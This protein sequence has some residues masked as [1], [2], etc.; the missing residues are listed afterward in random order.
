MEIQEL[1][2]FISP[3]GEV[4]YEVRG[5]KGKRCLDITR[6]LE[7]DLGGEIL[8]REETAEMRETEIDQHIER[9]DTVTT[10]V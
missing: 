9:D 4:R 10:E 3:D 1:E 5:V 8:S 6:D 7:S 2:L